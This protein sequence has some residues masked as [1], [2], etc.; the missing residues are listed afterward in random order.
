VCGTALI[1]DVL[2]TVPYF[3]RHEEKWRKP[4]GMWERFKCIIMDPPRAAW[5]IVH[6]PTQG[7]GAFVFFM[8]SFLYGLVG[9]VLFDKLDLSA[10]SLSPDYISLA[11]LG[12]YLSFVVIGIIYTAILWGLILL[13]QTIAQ[14][15]VANV[16]PKWDKQGP[17]LTWMFF[18]SL[19]ATGLYVVILAIGLP[20]VTLTAA[21]VS[22]SLYSNLITAIGSL[23]INSGTGSVL[24]TW[25]V[26]DSITIA[27]YFGYLSVLLAIAYREF[28]DVS[29]LR[30]LVAT[31]IAG[32]ICAVI[33][34]YTRSTF[35]AGVFLG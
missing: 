6:K 29:T 9:V 2:E 27:F 24:A 1:K 11:G 21:E 28:Y 4:M 8:N 23:F 30:S 7:G 22:G 18:P 20:R 33:F 25:A 3:R 17:V 35:M 12:I 13:A 26:A 10:T 34:V 31:V 15:Y 16:I 19:L 14:K 5:D 32:I